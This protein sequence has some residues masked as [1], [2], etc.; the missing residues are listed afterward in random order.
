MS[1]SKGITKDVF[2]CN[3]KT[4]TYLILIKVILS[5]PGVDNHTIDIITIDADR[6]M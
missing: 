6:E 1:I 2:H 4:I 5:R 3:C